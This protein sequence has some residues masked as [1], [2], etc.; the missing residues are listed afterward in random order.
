MIALTVI[1][2]YRL[3]AASWA[4]FPEPEPDVLP[5]VHE[6]TPEITIS[7]TPSR[8]IAEFSLFGRTEVPVPAV[9][10]EA[11]PV[12][13][14]RL[15]LTLS[16]IL[17]SSTPDQ[18]MAIIVDSSGNEAFYGVGMLV[19]G[20]AVLAEVHD[21]YVLVKRESRL[22]KLTL[23]QDPD[24]AGILSDTGPAGGVASRTG[25]TVP[26]YRPPPA[27]LIRADTRT[28]G[29]IL[30]EMRQTLAEDPARVLDNMRAD[31]VREG[32]HLVGYRLNPARDR[33]LL[34][35]FGLV[36]GDI[37][38]SVNGVPLNNVNKGPE[39]VKALSGSNQLS[40]EVM[41]NGI[42]QKFSFKID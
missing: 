24:V 2:S 25:A 34:S 22:E 31:P 21:G 9:Q 26:S 8:S 37:V 17:V 39:I 10:V 42:T 16:G 1:I 4:I 36:P 33:Q 35:R 14:S 19:P 27:A 29:A 3:A 13:E 38:T 30:R 23:P 41:R 18:G 5:P 6:L 28:N 12:V 32:D 40:L 7:K 11:P 15:N 20:G